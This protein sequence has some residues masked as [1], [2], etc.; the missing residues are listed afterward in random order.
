MFAKRIGKTE[1]RYVF[2]YKEGSGSKTFYRAEKNIKGKC[3]SIANAT[4]KGA[5]KA[6]DIK[7]IENGLKPINILK[8][9]K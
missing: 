6:L 3:I 7:L 2:E 1:Y 5:A 8:A 9:K 4:A